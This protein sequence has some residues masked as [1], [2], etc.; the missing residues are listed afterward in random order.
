VVC[1][2]CVELV[3]AWGQSGVVSPPVVVDKAAYQYLSNE[4]VESIGREDYLDG[5]MPG[6]A[7]D[8]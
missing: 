3:T 1:L 5:R 6:A 4:A 2:L 8:G 7:H